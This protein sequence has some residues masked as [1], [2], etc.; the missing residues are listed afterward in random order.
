M[1]DV[2]DRFL[3]YVQVHTTSDQ[4]NFDQTPSTPCQFDLANKVAG[5]LS[6]MGCE[7]VKVDEHAY[8]TATVPASAGAEDLPALGLCAHLDTT[9]D[10]PGE[11]VHPRVVAYDGGV[12]RVGTDPYGHE[13][14]V[15]PDETPGLEDYAGDQF[16]CAD[17]TTL[18]GA[19]DKAA[20][21][22]IVSLAARLLAHPEMP[23]PRLRLALVPDEEIGHGARL[24]DLDEFGAEW[25]YTVDGE[26]T[27]SFMYE[28]FNACMVE[29]TVNGVMVHPG[30]AKD[31]MVNACSIVEELDQ[32]LPAHERPEHTDGYEG[33]YHLMGFEGTPAHA[34]AVY[35]LRDFDADSFAHRKEMLQSAADHLNLRYGAGTVEVS[36]TDQY[37]NMAEYLHDMPFLV[38]N[39]LEAIRRAGLTP[40]VEP[41]RGGTDGAQLTFRGLPCPNISNGSLNCHGFKELESVSGLEKTVDILQQLVALFAQP[42]KQ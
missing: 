30:T 35:I 26:R 12:L 7:D 6:D 29:V 8:V 4:D 28:C 11:E 36:I 39:G 5:E 2:L 22:E 17:G 20:V 40:K 18:L 13:V 34:R 32:M 9:P 33:Y 23:R 38:E 3:G 16:V 42:Q 14:T 10:A 19:D 1:S 15:S 37:R 41:I 31:I 25:C 21:A 27:G 24:L